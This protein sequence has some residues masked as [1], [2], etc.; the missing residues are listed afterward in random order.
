[1]LE[2]RRREREELA[3]MLDRFRG[4]GAIR[5]SQLAALSETEFRYMLHWIGRAFETPKDARGVRRADSQDGRARIVL[6][7]A[8]HSELIVLQ[9]PQGRFR[10]PDYRIEVTAR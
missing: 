5:L 8:E 1:M 2:R 6:Q 4:L 7:P 9:V 3:L 10:T